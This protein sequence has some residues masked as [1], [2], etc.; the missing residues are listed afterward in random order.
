MIYGILKVST[1]EFKFSRAGH[2]SLLLIDYKGNYQFLTPAG[3]GVGLDSGRLFLQEIEETTLKLSKGDMLV[4]YTDGITEAMNTQLEPFGEEKMVEMFIP[5][6]NQP[7]KD[8]QQ[9]ILD[10]LTRYA[11]GQEIHDDLTMII[12]RRNL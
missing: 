11:H 12:I 5:P 6:K 8:Y 10:V 3:I 9:Q 4:F 7:V 1:G 2:N